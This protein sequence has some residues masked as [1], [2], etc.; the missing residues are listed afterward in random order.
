[1]A[2]TYLILRVSGASLGGKCCLVDWYEEMSWL[3]R[4]KVDHKQSVRRNL[5]RLINTTT[6][7]ASHI[8]IDPSRDNR[9]EHRIVR[10]LPVVVLPLDGDAKADAVFVGLTLDISSEGFCI[11][12]LGSLQAESKVAVGIGVE[13][14]FVVVLCR[15]CRSDAIGYG[16]YRS[17]LEALEQLCETDYAALR[18]LGQYVE[19]NPPLSTMSMLGI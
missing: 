11:S 14:D 3:F 5:S 4:S 12:T 18:E 2:A 16:Y 15:C 13:D 10:H 9:V 19:A 7:L 8:A 6:S 17:G 1:M